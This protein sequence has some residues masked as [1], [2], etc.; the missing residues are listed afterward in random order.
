MRMLCKRFFCLYL[1]VLFVG[2]IHA[3]VSDPSQKYSEAEKTR[4]IQRLR[5][6][7]SQTQANIIKSDSNYNKAM[8]AAAQSGYGGYEDINVQFDD[9]DKSLSVAEKKSIENSK[10]NAEIIRETTKGFK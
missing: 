6:L 9:K 5:K 3:Q 8:F 10:R 1:S 7:S 2:P 4:Q